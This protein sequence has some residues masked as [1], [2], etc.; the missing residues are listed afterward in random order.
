[1]IYLPERKDIEEEYDKL[2]ELDIDLIENKYGLWDLLHYVEEY[3]VYKD[4]SQG[5]YEDNSY[6]IDTTCDEII[7]H[8]EKLKQGLDKYIQR[9]KEAKEIHNRRY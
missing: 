4:S 1:M 6:F 5:C 7:D 3:D 2:M 9:F 8:L